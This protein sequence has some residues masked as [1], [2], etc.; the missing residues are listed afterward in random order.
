[1]A[2]IPQKQLFDWTQ[3]E[4]MGDLA[5]LQLA[6]DTLPDEA[7]MRNLERNRGKGRDDYPVRAVW[8]SILAAV[9]FQHPSIES[10]RRELVDKLAEHHP[11]L[12]AAC[13]AL[14]AD[15]GY[16]DTNGF[17]RHFIRGLAKMRLRCGL[18]LVVMVA[19]ALWHAKAKR[20]ELVRSLVRRA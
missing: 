18:A 7:L 16:D 2:I 14:C 4:A 11:E 9:V 19:L 3:V 12:V 5:R 1:M 13:D 20:V 17:E 10:L 8:N 6:L 15:K